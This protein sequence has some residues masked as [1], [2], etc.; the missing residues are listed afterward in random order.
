VAF[1]SG[2]LAFLTVGMLW[3][4]LADLNSGGALIVTLPVSIIRWFTGILAVFGFFFAENFHVLNVLS[5][6]LETL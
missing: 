5:K 4:A 3:L 1:L 6:N 2:L